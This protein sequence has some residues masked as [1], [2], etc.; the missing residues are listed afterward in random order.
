[1]ANNLAKL[2]APVQAFEEARYPYLDQ[3]LIEFLL[4][5]PADQLLR[6]GE[7]RSLMRRSLVGIVPQEILSRRTKQVGERTPMLILEKCWDELQDIY[8]ASFSSRLGYIHEAQLMKTI[9]DAHAGKSVS[10]V[11]VLWTI[12]LEYWLR[13]LA[14]RG[15]FAPPVASAL[16]FEQRQMPISA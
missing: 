7:R 6:P 12:S 4:S 8:Q 1:M 13:D 11:R 3:T 10:L 2:T 14:G 5:I 9:C 16:P 15:L